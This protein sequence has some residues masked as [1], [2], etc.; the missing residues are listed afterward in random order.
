MKLISLN[1]ITDNMVL[2]KNVYA[3]EGNVL[4]AKD[5]PLKQTYATK[6]L[7]WGVNSVYVR[8]EQG[9]LLEID[10]ELCQQVQNSVFS[11]F[12]DF[13]A[14]VNH[15]Q[16]PEKVQQKLET[17]LK[18]LLIDGNVLWNLV[19]IR[20]ISEDIFRHCVNVCIISMIIGSFRGY[21][22]NRLTELATGAIL[23]DLGKI[24]VA[25]EFLDDPKISLT[26]ENIEIQEHTRLGFEKLKQLKGNYENAAQVV[27]QHH[28]KY[29]GTGFPQGLKGD[30]IHEF[31]RIASIADIFHLQQRNIQDIS[32]SQMIRNYSGTFF[33]PELAQLFSN[34]IAPFVD[35]DISGNVDTPPSQNSPE[36][37]GQISSELD[38]TKIKK[39]SDAEYRHDSGSQ[40]ESNSS[41]LFS[42]MFGHLG[43]KDR[44]SEEAL[45][46][47]KP[48]FANDLEPEKNR[49]N[50]F[51]GEKEQKSDAIAAN[52]TD[53]SRI[54][55]DNPGYD[56]FVVYPEWCEH[57]K[58]VALKIITKALTRISTDLVSKAVIETTQKTLEQVLDDNTIIRN[59]VTIQ[60]LDENIFEHCVTVGLLSVM[61]GVSLGYTEEQLNELATGSLLVDLGKVEIS[62]RYN[63]DARWLGTTEYEAIMPEHTQF[64][65]E[66]L[67]KLKPNTST[68]YIA[69]QHHE[70]YDGSGYPVGLRGEQINELA[71]IVALAD[72]YDSLI[73]EGMNGQRLLPHEV[74]EYI[75]DF[76]GSHFDP[77][78]CRIF[79]QNMIPLLVGSNVL[80]NTGEKAT[81]IR[82]NKELLAR[83]LIRV[84]FDKDGNKLATPIAKDLATDLTLFIVGALK[85][86]EF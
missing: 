6:L 31:A 13:L 66:Q 78:I 72:V 84:I 8:D 74:I 61:T 53:T 76:S 34:Q 55:K 25:H 28:E 22:D 49:I 24:T 19:E 50:P 2:A 81:V 54:S 35:M 5:A 14:D 15:N 58:T 82:I 73:H 21:P 77:E 39:P 23:I 80:L 12:R 71:R 27:L 20:A 44:Y 38:Q 33:D 1:K 32:P 75:R 4:L 45:Q 16:L 56:K 26:Q 47:T 67:W 52:R 11:Y 30:Q 29:D 86:D 37:T 59:L 10:E 85:D 48:D 62:R 41:S 83:P 9:D 17:I 60:A 69:L 70:R 3:R 7:E 36:E 43:S 51:V 18:Q 40:Q 64:G 46:R 57:T 63:V 65:F 42:K 79:L 68:P